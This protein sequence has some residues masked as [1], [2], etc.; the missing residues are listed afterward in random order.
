M[1]GRSGLSWSRLMQ[2]LAGRLLILFLLVLVLVTGF[3]VFH[4]W[5]YDPYLGIPAGSLVA[6]AAD[7]RDGVFYRP[8]VSPDGSYGGTRYFPLYWVTIGLL[9][10]L[11]V[12]AV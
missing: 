7:L 2:S 3:R 8:L 12:P 1:L 6:M 9:M 4:A 11:G 10:K 5:R